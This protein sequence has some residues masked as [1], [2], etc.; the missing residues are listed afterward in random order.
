MIESQ[1]A[2]RGIRDECVLRAMRE[3]A[4]SEFVPSHLATSAHEDR[5]L[6]IEEGQTISQ[7]FIVALMAVAAE[8]QPA[9]RV[10]EVGTGSGYAAAVLSRIANHVYT[11]E[12][13]A[14]LAER[15]QQRFDRLGYHNI[16]VSIRD[17]SLGWAD[18]APYNAIV[19]AAGA[20]ARA[21][22]PLK[23]QLAPGGRLIIPRGDTIT[24]Q[25][26]VRVRRSE[27][28]RTFTEDR[29][30]AVAF[31]PLIGAAAWQDADLR[32]DATGPAGV[33]N[34][35]AGRGSTAGNP[36]GS[37]PDRIARSAEA[38][39]HMES[40]PLPGLLERIGNARL[41]L[42]G[43][44]S[45]GT[46]EFYW[47]RSLI[48][49]RLIEEEGFDFVAVEADWP[50]AAEI[51]AYVRHHPYERP[52]IKP[53]QRFPRWMWANTDVLAFVRWLRA[54]NGS[55]QADEIKVGFHGM[56]LY[57][58][59]ASI[60]AVLAYLDDVDPDVSRITRQRYACL[61]PWQDDP[62][63]Y[64]RAAFDDRFIACEEDVLAMLD[65][66]LRKRLEYTRKDG[67]RF[68]DAMQNARLVA[69]AERYY[70]TMYHGTVSSWNLRDQHMFDTLLLLFAQ[71]GPDS[72]GIVW[73]HNSHLGDASATAM[74]ARGEHNVGQLAR[75]RYARDA[76]LI[77]FGTHTG[78]VA[79]ASDWG[80]P[81]EIMRVRP[82]HPRS[83]ERLAHD[84]GVENFLLH[85]RDPADSRLR[86]DLIEPRLERAI[87]VIY[88]P[89]TEL[90]SHYFSAC[91]PRQF[92]EWIWF[93]DTTAVT[94]IG[95]EHVEPLEGIPETYPFG[96]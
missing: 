80:E 71:Y 82:S 81:M 85:L 78:T 11:V 29:L 75:Q 32:T 3:V 51:D 46:S 76:Y 77:G 24:G 72:R 44:A 94:P 84:A 56:D 9:D 92:D 36:A 6:P 83:Y 63:L 26:L 37:I 91:L 88:R 54:F 57:S 53:F 41:V 52:R 35:P 95:S 10:L 34:G 40:A 90:Q 87:G 93:D 61:M 67:A 20:P 49:Q 89:D 31:V 39:D 50:D 21:L 79:A 62:I 64:G 60:E 28:G 15:A 5:A 30:G 27:D 70:R 25:E 14:R 68:F 42:L 65:D 18:H 16:T 58:M 13:H 7:P 17:G 48:T 19:V 22:Q 73:A 2:S 59:Y 23:E 4:R 45:H 69:N 96:I 43:E 33:G 66:L 12:R 38:F 74:G 55:A 8:L 1:I 47:M 86:N